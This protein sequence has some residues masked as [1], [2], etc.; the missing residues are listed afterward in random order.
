[1]PQFRGGGAIE[2]L[3]VKGGV[4]VSSIFAERRGPAAAGIR[5]PSL[6]EDA[7]LLWERGDR[8]RLGE[9]DVFF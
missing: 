5:A 4:P 1:M 8:S 3:Q 6:K 2:A 7:C 9:E